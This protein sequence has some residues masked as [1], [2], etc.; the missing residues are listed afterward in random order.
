MNSYLLQARSGGVVGR[1]NMERICAGTRRVLPWFT[2]APTSLDHRRAS[3]LISPG[4]GG[5]GEK[6]S[7]EMLPPRWH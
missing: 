7:P 5:A 2:P 4:L 3:T 6:L 1:E